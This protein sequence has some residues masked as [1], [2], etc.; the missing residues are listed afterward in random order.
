MAVM[1]GIIIT[2]STTATV[3]IVRPVPETGPAK[4][5]SQPRLSFS[6]AKDGCR[7]GASTVM[8]QSPNTTEGTAAS[9]S[10]MYP[11]PW[12]MRRGA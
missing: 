2:A 6:Q 11:R 5:G 9:R 10:M 7:S 3:R 4:N 8:P 12:A 1:M